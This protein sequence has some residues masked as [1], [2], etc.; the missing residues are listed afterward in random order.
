MVQIKPF[1]VEEWMDR[2]ENTPGALN[3]AE[4]CCDS[5]SIRDLE[6]LSTDKD[7]Q[8][9]LDRIAKSR[10]TYG[11]ILGSDSTRQNIADLY[12]NGDQADTGTLS[13]DQV[14]LTQ[15]A[16]A[17]NY[18]LLYSLVG[19]GDHVVC[20]YPTYQQL[21]DVPR[22]LGAEVS[23][24][25][26]KK[27]NGFVPDIAELEGLLQKNTKVCGRLGCEKLAGLTLRS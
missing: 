22:S 16:I 14:V 17:A 26:L 15:G 6:N 2:L 5:V 9:P 20:V 3:V 27:E 24:W 8:G 19:P 11:A 13:K 21:Y 4:T 25:K 1:V 12:S 10:M 18:I 7:V 23:L